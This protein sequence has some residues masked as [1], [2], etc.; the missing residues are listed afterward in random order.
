MKPQS[1]RTLPL[2][3]PIIL[4]SKSTLKQ[5]ALAMKN[6]GIGSILVSDGHGLLKGLFTD[7]DLAFTMAIAGKNTSTPLEEVTKQRL[8]YVT[9]TATLDDVVQTMQQYAIRRIPVVH[10]RP[11]GRQRC[12]GVISFDDLVRERLIDAK[13]EA[14]I[15]KA[16]IANKSERLAQRR[17]KS[18][19]H[20]QDNKEQSYHHFIKTIASH[21]D[22]NSTQAHQLSVDLLT[23]LL[24]RMSSK[25]GKGLLSQLPYE[26][27]MQLMSQISS[28]DRSIGS[29]I[30]VSH[31]QKRFHCNEDSARDLLR[32]FW[33]GLSASLSAGEMRGLTRELPRDINSLFVSPPQH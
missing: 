23:L 20:S 2:H 22:L 24:R 6:N 32:N 27:Q 4:E 11:N 3:K 21:T 25:A 33:E 18:I 17:V 1:A 14:R 7:R 8:I 12:L 29:K 26:L 9:D 28:P 15:L 10:M 19:F 13:D 16:Q 30:F 5:A 31:I